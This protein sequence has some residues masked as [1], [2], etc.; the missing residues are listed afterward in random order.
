VTFE[1]CQRKETIMKAPK[2]IA[3][4]IVLQALI[5]FGQWTGQPAL[6]TA[7]ADVPVTNPGERQIA[8]L[9]ELKS[10]NDKMDRLIGLLQ[11]GDAKVEVTKV[12]KA[13]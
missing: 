10:L 9:D 3:V 4:V 5:L 1:N 13:T 8:I 11:S 12:D 2:L 7:Q 6:R